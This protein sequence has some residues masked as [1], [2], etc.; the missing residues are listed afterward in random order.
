MKRLGLFLGI[1]KG[2]VEVAPSGQEQLAFE[3]FQRNTNIF[4]EFPGLS[5][6]DYLL[7][8]PTEETLR[9]AC[10]RIRSLSK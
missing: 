5:I 2:L 9:T 10:F 8:S 7:D 4:Q 3:W 6:R 1:Y